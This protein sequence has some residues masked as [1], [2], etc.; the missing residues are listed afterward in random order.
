MNATNADSKIT[1][2]QSEITNGETPFNMN[3]QLI[4][5]LADAT[6]A[7]DALNRQTADGRYYANTTPLEQITIP[8]GNLLM[9][10]H[11]IE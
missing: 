3:Y 11:R 10:S 1:A 2:N 8:T 7:T 6:S 5:N 9:N 4:N